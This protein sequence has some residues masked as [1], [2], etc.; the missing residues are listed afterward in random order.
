[1]E[2]LINRL[3]KLESNRV[4]LEILPERLKELEAA[5]DG[6]RAQ[7][8]NGVQVTGG[9]GDPAEA[10]TANIE[11]RARLGEKVRGIAT[12]VMILDRA[13]GSLT[14]EERLVLELFYIRRRK[15]HVG[16]LKQRLGYESST[17][18]RIKDTALKRLSERLYGAE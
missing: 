3:E 14:E 10:L 7:K 1:M 2:R 12:E 13:L 16:E 15:D 4:A 11:E 6:L 9:G 18:Y 17:I 5:A 8:L